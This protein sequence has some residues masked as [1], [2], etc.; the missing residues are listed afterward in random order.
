MRP[1]P[2]TA[3]N[4]DAV[5]R[6][7]H[8]RLSRVV[9]VVVQR[10]GPELEAIL[11]CGGFGRGE[12]GVLARPDGRLHVIND[13]DLELVYRE[14]LGAFVSK[15]LVQWRHRRALRQLAESLAAEFA[16]KQ[17]DLSLR[18]GHTLATAVPKLADY[19]LRYGHRLLWGDKDPCERMRAFASS[20]VPA[21]EGT[22][23]LRNRGIGLVLARLYLDRGRLHEDNTE[24]FYIEVNKAALAMGDAL[25]ILSGRY[26]VQYAHR[27]AAFDTLATPGFARRDE[28][29]QWYRQAA[30]YKLRPVP[31]Q[32]PGVA[33]AA[34]WDQVA[35]LYRDFFVW[36]ESQRTGQAF[37]DLDAYAQWVDARPASRGGGRLRRW[38]DARLGV[39]GACPPQMRALKYDPQRSVLCVAAL[40]SARTGDS[41]AKRVLERWAVPD[42]DAA[43][44]WRTRARGLLSL[45]HP[46]GEVGR[47]L[48][49]SAEDTMPAQGLAA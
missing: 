30:E 14:P 22:W 19:D 34:L 2:Y 46:G 44:G 28:L 41:A 21:F 43:S 47:F 13:F 11:L 16:M 20:D 6:F 12:G 17:V 39:S 42:A 26:T 36:F 1:G 37:A 15:L 31:R 48:A 9:A 23:L 24:N 5:D 29:V 27:A 3:W 4:D 40:V 35:G 25:W 38:M 8:D 10:M 45:M 32:Y 33:A 49:D 7:V 18:A